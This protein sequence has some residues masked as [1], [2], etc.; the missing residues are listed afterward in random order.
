MEDFNLLK[1]ENNPENAG[2]QVDAWRDE[3]SCEVGDC[4][5]VAGICTM[6]MAVVVTGINC[7]LHD[8]G[9][10][11]G[12][13]CWLVN[14]LIIALLAY[15]RN[16]KPAGCPPNVLRDIVLKVW[17]SCAIFAVGFCLAAMFFNYVESQ[18]EGLEVFARV[19]VKPYR[20]VLL[21]MGMALSITGFI[22]KQSWVWI[23]G[24]VLGL[25][26]FIWISLQY[27]TYILSEYRALEDSFFLLELI[28][29]IVVEIFA[30]SCF[31]LPGHFLKYK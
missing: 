11:L 9:I 28:I 6:I 22:I 15:L 23:S 10:G 16:R 26:G 18:I 3:L 17:L 29:C 20:V 12:Q 25:G 24:I 27:S 21:V 31:V 14:P 8:W 30:F 13:V 7:L 19:A 5:F 1:P 2:D 4:L